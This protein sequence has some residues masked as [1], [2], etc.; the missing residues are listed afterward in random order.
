VHYTPNPLQV[1]DSVILYIYNNATS[2]PYQIT[3][4][5]TGDKPDNVI[6]NG[7][8]GN[9]NF[10]IKASPNPFNGIVNI[11]YVVGGTSGDYLQL[12]VI[13][14]NGRE[15]TRLVDKTMTPGQYNV[16]F[17]G[18]EISSGVYFVI[19]KL[20]NQSVQLPIVLKK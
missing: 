8:V 11:Q 1:K 12:Y 18:K 2:K 16:E 14:A 10:N 19:G 15:V 9:D 3:L 4:S 6:D 20:G 7:S 5:G 13:D 17:S